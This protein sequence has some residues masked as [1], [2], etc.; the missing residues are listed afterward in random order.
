MRKQVNYGI[1]LQWNIYAAIKN[2][3]YKEFECFTKCLHYNKSKRS[4]IQMPIT[5]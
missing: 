3:V 2:N 4:R 5:A 1:S